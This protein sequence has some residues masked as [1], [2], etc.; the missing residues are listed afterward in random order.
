MKKIFIYQL[1]FFKIYMNNIFTGYYQPC[2]NN[3]YMTIN[4][5]PRTQNFQ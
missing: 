2:T 1:D 3:D 4:E 5:K